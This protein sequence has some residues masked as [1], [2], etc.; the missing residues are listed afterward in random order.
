MVYEVFILR[1]GYGTLNLSLFLS[2]NFAS[3]ALKAGV[4]VP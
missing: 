1:A 2:W 3:G 4:D